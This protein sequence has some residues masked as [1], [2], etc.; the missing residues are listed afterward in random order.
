MTRPNTTSLRQQVALV[1][2]VL[3]ILPNV[4]MAATVLV[5][6]Y[7]RSGDLGSEAWFT[8]AVW[9]VGV[10][11]AAVL[12]GYLLSQQLLAPLIN[13]TRD[14]LALPVTAR[15]LTSAQLPLLGTEPS[16]VAALKRSFNDLLEQV[17]LEQSRRDSFMATVM[18][19]LKT[20]L[21]ASSHLLTVVRDAED[22]GRD[23]RITVVDHLLQENEALIALVQKLVDAHRFERSKVELALEETDIDELVRTTVARVAPLA[24]ERGLRIAVSGTARA[25][26]DRREFERALYNLIS[27][28]VRYAASEIDIRLYAG[29]IR[30]ADDGPGFPA[31]LEE[32][33]QPF[34]GRPIDIA[35]K[36]YT[37]GTSGLGLFIARRI[38]E[39]HGGR[40]V[41]EATGPGTTLLIYYGD[42]KRETP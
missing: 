23:E 7:R 6:L 38:I 33:A 29:L 3:S 13:V 26:V 42:G 27:N 10:V 30:L 19:D 18:H 11:L 40:L 41:T 39:A 31:P 32:L 8:I 21:V 4:V 28:A 9:M 24:A 1:I 37:S 25:S 17:R 15:S 36:R 5:P 20:P 2:A 22:L 14:I 35:G 34:K 16:E 12:I